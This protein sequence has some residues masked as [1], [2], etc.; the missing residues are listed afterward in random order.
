MSKSSSTSFALAMT[1][2]LAGAVMLAPSLVTAQQSPTA[3]RGII[4]LGASAPARGVQVVAPTTPVG[5][6]MIPSA[7][8][9]PMVVELP[10][11]QVAS[12]VAQQSDRNNVAW[13]AVGAAALMVG[14]LIGGDA[15]T[16]V[17]VTGG[18]I[19]LMGLFRY[20]N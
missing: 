2:L 18:V 13:M 7:T 5:P 1:W 8:W 19:G 4:E 3:D 12:A 17:A 16:V 14:L 15:G 9:R 11:E 20:M 10:G 6:V